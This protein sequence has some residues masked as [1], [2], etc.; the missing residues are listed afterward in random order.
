MDTESQK[1]YGGD[2]LMQIGVT[3][4]LVKEDFHAFVIHLERVETI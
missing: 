4:P 2:E 1:V 3:V